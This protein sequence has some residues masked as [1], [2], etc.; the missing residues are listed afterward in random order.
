MDKGDHETYRALVYV[1]C[2]KFMIAANPLTL[3]IRV[4]LDGNKYKF[5]EINAAMIG[6]HVYVYDRFHQQT[7]R[8]FIKEISYIL[9]Y[10]DELIRSK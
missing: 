4:N 1:L 6:Y 5:A 10:F 9:L 7:H 3:N 8:A 2:D